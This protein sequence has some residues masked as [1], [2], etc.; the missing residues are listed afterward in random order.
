MKKPRKPARKAKAGR[1]SYLLTGQPTLEQTAELAEAFRR[2]ALEPTTQEKAQTREKV[3]AAQTAR[4]KNPK[5]PRRKRTAKKYDAVLEILA[6]ID[7]SEGLPS[8]L[9]PAEIE[10]KVL[11]KMPSEL[12]RRWEK[13][14]PD[15]RLIKKA[16]SRKVINEAYQ[17]YLKVRP[18]K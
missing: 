9:T 13:R 3:Q 1:K 7:Q 2:A 15:D 11:F 8:D 6:D 16:V 17:D 5:P 12:R 14:G 10:K 18:S 4:P